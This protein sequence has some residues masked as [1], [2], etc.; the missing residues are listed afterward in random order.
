M[1]LILIFS[2]LLRVAGVIYSIVLWRRLRDW[3]IGTLAAILVLLSGRQI[4]TLINEIAHPHQSIWG[5]ATE[6]PALLISF[7]TLLALFLF[8]RMLTEKQR[9]VDALKI[10]EH[11]FSK[12]FRYTPDSIT[13]FRLDDGAVIDVNEGFEKMT[14]F[15][16]EEAIGRTTDDLGIWNDKQDRRRF[17]NMIQRD[18]RVRDFESTIRTRSG[19]V[20]AFQA[21]SESFNLNGR[22]HVVSVARDIS[23]SRQRQRELIEAIEGEQRRIGHDLHDSL[24]QDL[25]SV[26]LQ[27]QLVVNSTRQQKPAQSSPL[28]RINDSLKQVIENTRRMA[29][30][31]SPVDLEQGGLPTALRRLSENISS[32]HQ[33]KC[34]FSCDREFPVLPS[35]AALQLYRIIQEAVNNAI[36][37]SRCST[38]SIKLRSGTESLVLTVEDNGVGMDDRGE[39]AGMGLSIMDYRARALGGSI[40]H[41]SHSTGGTRIR[42]VF[43]AA[44][45]VGSMMFTPSRPSSLATNSGNTWHG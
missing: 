5:H 7:L 24:A 44:Q 15:S 17:M 22:A 21:S 13:I 3:R 29:Q 31:L 9:A 45:A 27:L 20:R 16:R 38:I 33:L 6:I 23:H 14:G 42:C 37:H 10:S 4:F 8:G 1:H 26:A 28:E 30:G 2:I 35:A 41:E 39:T 40:A 11:K 34:N 19:K 12:A 18:G 32:M 25:V 36:R 43:P